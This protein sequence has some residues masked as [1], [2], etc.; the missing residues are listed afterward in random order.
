MGFHDYA[1]S[2][3][4]ALLTRALVARTDAPLRQLQTMRDALES[5]VRALESGPSIDGDVTEV[6]GRLSEAADA[7]ERRTRDE[8]NATLEAVRGELDLVRAE[9]ERLRVERDTE[10]ADFDRVR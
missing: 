4:S 2:E 9:V 10:R 6:V 3:T 5:V 7:A 1:A 8:V